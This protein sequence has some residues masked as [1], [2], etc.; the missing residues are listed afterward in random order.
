MP[1]EHKMHV[2]RKCHQSLKF[3]K[4][5]F[6]LSYATNSLSHKEIGPHFSLIVKPTIITEVL[7]SA[8]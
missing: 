7:I 4:Q 3:E 5:N 8:C 1:P 2:M 6:T